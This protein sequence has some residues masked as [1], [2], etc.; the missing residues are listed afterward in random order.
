MNESCPDC[1]GDIPAEATFCRHCGERV[2]G[3]PCEACGARN[4]SEATRCRWCGER[5]RAAGHQVDFESFRVTARLLPTAL[6]RGRFL[7]QEI[8]LT[9]E[10]ILVRTPGPFNLTQGEEEIPWAKVAG[11]D[12]HA[13]LFWDRVT[14]ETR[15][16][17]ST[18]IGGLA[19][20]EGERI[21]ELLRRLET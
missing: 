6:F 17:S 19:K 2:E 3:K 10:K 5:Y 12:Y 14:I 21:R 20:P 18:V 15:G 9:Q 16:Q 11:F 8:T 1:L 7:P 13:G 4:W